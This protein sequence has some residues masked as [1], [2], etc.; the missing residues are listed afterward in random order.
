MSAKMFPCVAFRGVCL[1]VLGL[2]LLS[3]AMS[4]APT[5]KPI[6]ILPQL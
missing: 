3:A 5:P 2:L 1:P 6:S 4:P